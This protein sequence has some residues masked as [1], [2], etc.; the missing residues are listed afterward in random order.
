MK[1]TLLAI[2]A[3]SFLTLSAFADSAPVTITGSYQAVVDA[4]AGTVTPVD[5][6][7]AVPAAGD[8]TVMVDGAS[9]TVHSDGTT[10]T[11]ATSAAPVAAAPVAKN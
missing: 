1:K 8:Y 10:L 3:S 11:V 7:A 4:K 9:V 2:A 5:K 6:T